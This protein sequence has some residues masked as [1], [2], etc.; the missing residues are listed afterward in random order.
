MFLTNNLQRI[1][2]RR[3]RD[4]GGAVLVIMEN[5]NIEHSLQRLFYI[6]AFR[7]LDIFEV[8]TTEG[9]RNCSYDLDD[10]I[11]VM[12][13]YFDIEH[14]NVSKFFEQ[15]TFSLHDW[16]AGECTTVAKPKNGGT[17]RDHRNQVAFR[18]VLI[19]ILWIL[20]DL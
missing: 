16:L 19:S 13:I 18:C 12:G 14:I 2:Q 4:N 5:G 11:R 17:I 15:Y 6:K 8:D 20:F 1:C 9:R 10:F 3:R 7:C